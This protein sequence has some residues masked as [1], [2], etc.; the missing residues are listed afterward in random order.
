M[1]APD[2]ELERAVEAHPLSTSGLGTFAA[3][4]SAPAE[5]HIANPFADTPV[6]EL[7]R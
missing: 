1:T 3:L 5:V 7:T 2:L 4:A 6:E